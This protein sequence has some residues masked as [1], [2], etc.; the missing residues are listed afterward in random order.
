MRPL[1]SL[2][3]CDVMVLLTLFCLP[4][5]PPISFTSLFSIVFVLVAYL[6]QYSTVFTLTLLL[7]V[8]LLPF[9]FESGVMSSKRHKAE[10]LEVPQPVI[11]STELCY[12]T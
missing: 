5:P 3:V 12:S 10:A 1:P 4:P 9:S 6:S 8:C 2:P 11:V 7:T